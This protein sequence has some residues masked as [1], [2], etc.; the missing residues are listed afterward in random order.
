MT[1]F[2]AFFFGAVEFPTRFLVGIFKKDDP[3]RVFS[4]EFLQKTAPRAFS[5]RSFEER[6]PL[7]R[8][9]VG[10]LKKDDP[11]RVFRTKVDGNRRDDGRPFNLLVDGN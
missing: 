8:F 10:N 6:R 4:S 3:S 7:A 2:Y 5:R 1:C 11:S 9:L